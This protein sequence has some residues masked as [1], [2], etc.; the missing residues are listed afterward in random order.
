MSIYKMRKFGNKSR[1]QGRSTKRGESAHRTA[2]RGGI[3]SGNAIR[4]GLER[5]VIQIE[6]LQMEHLNPA[7]FDLTLGEGVAEYIVDGELD[8]RQ[9]PYCWH[10]KIGREGIVLQPGRAYLMHTA[11]K[12][13]T[14]RY[15]PVLDGKSSLGRLFISVHETAGYID[16]GFAGQITL[17]V[18]VTHPVRVYAG[19]RFCQIRFHS[20]V[21]EPILYPE[22]GGHYVGALAE[23]A[24]PSMCH[25]QVAEFE[26]AERRR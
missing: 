17:E 11:E 14:T 18:T 13:H 20:I 7:S 3:L 19:M 23:G 10:Y 5:G 21:G 8:A 16:P 2:Y 25:A 22:T 4:E 26:N 1:H 6:P 24:V 12:V 9:P 15:V